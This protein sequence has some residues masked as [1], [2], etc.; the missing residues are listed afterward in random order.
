MASLVDKC[1]VCQCHAWDDASRRFSLFFSVPRTHGFGD[2]LPSPH[3]SCLDEMSEAG[4][5]GCSLLIEAFGVALK[6]NPRMTVFAIERPTGQSHIKLHWIQWG[7][8][9]EWDNP[10]GITRQPF[11]VY[12]SPG[13]DDEPSSEDAK[14]I[15]NRGALSSWHSSKEPFA[16][17]HLSRSESTAGKQL[18]F[19]MSPNTC[20]VCEEYA[21]CSP[22]A[23]G[24]EL[25]GGIARHSLD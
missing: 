6:D 5:L 14:L 21:L 9:V 2:G 25:Q 19:E 15:G 20:S 23:F 17:G 8:G 12:T 24:L 22:E 11:E 18:A 16:A 4:C 7:N 10:G 3:I 1:G 13:R